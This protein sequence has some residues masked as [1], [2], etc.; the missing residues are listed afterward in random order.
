[1]TNTRN[2]FKARFSCSDNFSSDQPG[3][4][5]HTGFFKRSITFAINSPAVT[6]ETYYRADFYKTKAS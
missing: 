1:M 3:G 5:S 6:K 4:K 2:V